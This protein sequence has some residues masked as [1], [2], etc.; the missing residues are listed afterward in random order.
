M[1]VAVTCL[2]DIRPPGLFGKDGSRSARRTRVAEEEAKRRTSL[3][4]SAQNRI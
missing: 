1:K 2:G 3:G 4:E